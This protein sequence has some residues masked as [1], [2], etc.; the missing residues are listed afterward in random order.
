M[1]LGNKESKRN[2]SQNVWGQLLSV[3]DSSLLP[4]ASLL[5]D[6]SPFIVTSNFVVLVYDFVSSVNKVNNKENNSKF[7][8]VLKQF[9]GI[10]YN[11]YALSRS[12]SINSYKHYLD[13][14]QVNKLP[15]AKDI[16]I[17]KIKLL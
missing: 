10:N 14:Q 9:T 5:M 11:V 6:G 2:L 16:E 13:L 8:D 3:N 15:R 17:D 12:D 4:F 7:S 1:V